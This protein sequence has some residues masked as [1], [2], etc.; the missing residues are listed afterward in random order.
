MD[1]EAPRGLLRRFDEVED[2]RVER[3]KLHRLPDILVITLCAVICGADRKKVRPGRT[4]HG[5]PPA[6]YHFRVAFRVVNVGRPI[7]L[8]RGRK[9]EGASGTH[10]TWL[11]NPR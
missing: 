6:Q 9:K 2:P 8:W 10:P 3:T 5:C 1:V 4:L 7:P 11:E